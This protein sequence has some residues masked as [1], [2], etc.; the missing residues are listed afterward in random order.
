MSSLTLKHAAVQSDDT[1]HII[2][3]HKHMRTLCSAWVHKSRRLERLTIL[4]PKR[5]QMRYHNLM[6]D[7]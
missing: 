3:G 5:D 4:P 6:C 2:S 7:S 1:Y